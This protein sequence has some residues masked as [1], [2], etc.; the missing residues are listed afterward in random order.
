MDCLCLA[1]GRERRGVTIGQDIET[2]GD[3]VNMNQTARVGIELGQSILPY[4]RI[5][6]EK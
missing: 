4:L 5:G 1:T 3:G 2:M 6:L